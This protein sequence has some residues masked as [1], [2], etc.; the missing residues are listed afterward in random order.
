MWAA[1]VA[2]H[3]RVD[4]LKRREV[5]IVQDGH[6]SDENVRMSVPLVVQHLKES[7]DK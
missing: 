7:D 1:Q 2:A 3:L 4:H 5:D 6:V